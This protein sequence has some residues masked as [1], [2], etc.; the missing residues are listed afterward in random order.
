[1]RMKNIRDQKADVPVKSSLT[2]SLF[3]VPGI[4][5]VSASFA[6]CEPNS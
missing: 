3:L 1:M 4:S 2:V 5:K 6:V